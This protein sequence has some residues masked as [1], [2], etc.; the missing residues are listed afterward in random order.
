[1]EAVRKA[2]TKYWIDAW[3]ACEICMKFFSAE[4]FQIQ[5]TDSKSTANT[6]ND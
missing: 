4:N 5:P 2:T 1:M 6:K 3:Q